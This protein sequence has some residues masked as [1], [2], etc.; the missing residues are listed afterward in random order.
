MLH[1]GHSPFHESAT[2][3]SPL[4]SALQV[5]VERDDQR[6]NVTFPL[7]P[8][9]TIFPAHAQPGRP[10]YFIISGF[11]LVDGTYDVFAEAG[12]ETEYYNEQ[13]VQILCGPARAADQQRVVISRVLKC[14][15]TVGYEDL[16]RHNVRTS[17]LYHPVCV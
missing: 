2:P 17:A 11:V 9:F 15:A 13:T 12:D 16:E 7:K 5:T 8:Y 10:S 3:F 1:E 14:T 6:L 4:H